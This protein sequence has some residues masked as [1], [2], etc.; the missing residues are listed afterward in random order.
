MNDPVGVLRLVDPFRAGE[1]WV[2]IPPPRYRVTVEQVRWP[3]RASDV[4]R[5]AATAAREDARIVHGCGGWANVLAAAAARLVRAKAVWTG[6]PARVSHA[7]AARSADA[8]VCTSVAERDRCVRR[9]GIPAAKVCVVHPG[10]DPDRFLPRAPAERPLIAAV[11]PLFARHGHV[12]FLEALVRVRRE[13][14]LVRAVCAGEGPV[15]PLLEQRMAHL[16]LR[17]AV[18]LAGHVDDVP[19]LLARAHAAWTPGP[20]ATIEAMAAGVPVASPWG[21]LIG[22]EIAVGRHHVAALAS[23]LLACLRDPKSAEAV[24]RRALRE[25]SLDASAQRLGAVYDT[26]LAPQRAAA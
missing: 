7:L 17:E 11:G 13:V 18:E 23:R 8:I 19:A 2:P 9:A 20:R 24:R 21:E 5:I 10:V 16:G 25:F 14:P 12:E 6:A 26:L 3:P 1:A 4:P 15:R 22:A